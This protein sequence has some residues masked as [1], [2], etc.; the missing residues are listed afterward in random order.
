MQ[1]AI[2][3]ADLI[4]ALNSDSY[5]GKTIGF[6]PTMGALHRGHVSLIERAGNECDKVVASIFVNPAQ[7]NDPNDL[8]NYPRTPDHDLKMLRKAG[9][10]LLFHPSAEEVYDGT[11]VDVP[12]PGPMAEIM[13]G[14]FRPG[15]FK[16][17]MMV[18]RRLLELICPDNAYF[19]EKDYQQLAVIRFMVKE[20]GIPVN[21]IGCATIREDD[22]LAMSSRNVL[23]SPEERAQASSVYKGLQEAAGVFKKSGW[24][25]AQQV[26]SKKLESSGLFRVEYVQVADAD[27]L[28]PAERFLENRQ[29][30]IFTAVSCSGTRLIDN[31]PV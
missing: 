20:V 12:D 8:K 22:G 23:L 15:H 4:S 9:C 28:I 3:R 21:V 26:F 13:E 27:T 30:R 10:D 14:K 19:G 11:A 16:G 29:Y 5:L 31:I 6:V 24:A 18:V 1:I 2:N 7:F 25:E 17:V